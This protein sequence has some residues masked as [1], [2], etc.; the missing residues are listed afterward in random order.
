MVFDMTPTQ[1]MHEFS[2]QIPQ[3]YHTFALFDAFQTGNLM[4]PVGQHFEK[5]WASKKDMTL[6][7][8]F[9]LGCRILTKLRKVMKFCIFNEGLPSTPSEKNDKQTQ[10]HGGLVQMIFLFQENDTFPACL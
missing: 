8:H 7:H 3:F 9:L 10:S 1:T 4:T 2:G 5:L 6:L